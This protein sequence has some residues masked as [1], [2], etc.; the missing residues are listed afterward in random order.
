MNIAEAS[1]EEAR[2]YLVLA[3]ELSYGEDPV[4][5]SQAEEVA[6]LLSAYS[7]ALRRPPRDP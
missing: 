3:A 5:A 6:K 1:L 2:Y 7:S 4:L